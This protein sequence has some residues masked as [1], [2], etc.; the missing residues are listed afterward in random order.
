[1]KEKNYIFLQNDKII[2]FVRYNSFKDRLGEF[3][4]N[5]NNNPNYSTL[6]K[7]ITKK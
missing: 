3:Y 1:M 7:Y 2:P 5:L 4:W 6:I